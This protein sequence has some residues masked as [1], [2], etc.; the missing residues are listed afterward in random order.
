MDVN[1]LNA[2]I[3]LPRSYKRIIMLVMDMVSLSLAGVMAYW[4]TSESFVDPLSLAV[5]EALTLPVF[6]RLGM[7]R[8]IIRFMG[9]KAL[10]V[11]FLAVSVSST[12]FL[13]LNMR[14]NETLQPVN[15]AIVYGCFSLFLVG[16]SRLWAR[17]IINVKLLKE[18]KK[19]VVIYGAGSSGIQL[20]KALKNG[21]SFT[22]VA[23]LDDRQSLQ[24]NELDGVK[25]LAPDEL[26]SVIAKTNVQEIFL[27]IPSSG[28]ERRRSIVTFL[29]QFPLRIRTV[30]SLSEILSGEARIE[31][32]QDIDIEELLGRDPVQPDEKLLKACVEHKIVLV[33]GAGGSIGSELCRQL[34]RLNPA[35]LILFETCEYALYTIEKELRKIVSR[36]H[37]KSELVS[38]LGNV[39][40]QP[41]IEKI[42][43]TFSVNTIYHAA[44]YKH[45]PMVEHNM[46]EG[47]RNN[48]FGTWVVALTA[49]KHQVETFVLISTDKAVRPTNVMGATKRMAELILQG[50]AQL[51]SKTTFCMVRFGNVLDSS[52]SVVPLFREQLRHGGPVT[53]THPEIIRYFMTIPEASQLVIQA[54]SLACGGDVFV[55][56]MG[57]PVKIADLARKMIHLMGLV[58]KDEQHP[59][60]IEIKYTG[61]R[62]GE[63]LFEELLIGETAVCTSHPRIM[64]AEETSLSWEA[65]ESFIRALRKAC[66]AF[67]CE[68][69]RQLLLSCET[70]YDPKEALCDILWQASEKQERRL[71]SAQVVSVFKSFSEGAA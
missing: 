34:I 11:V 52:G 39:Q 35:T 22:P 51:E 64:R 2:I 18:R 57:E 26:E 20:L 44:A 63:K 67:D 21:P 48:I 62:P 10:L 12:F 1:G 38:L 60:G 70:G 27:A 54:G 68:Q 71:S 49:Q 28:R 9:E 61:L 43:K 24:G 45:V 40:D 46:I 17:W 33:T 3:E 5:T 65:V 7:Y 16:G 55:L 53:V 41:R 15:M 50:L 36:H 31:E 14:A 13:L 23:L 6:I 25:V 4:L 58:L 8:S 37:L 47:V 59:R 69:V 66:D 19:P 30:P 29:E 56:D 42:L 32:V